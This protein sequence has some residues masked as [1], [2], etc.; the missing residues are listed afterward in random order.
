[1]PSVVCCFG[2]WY[3]WTNFSSRCHEYWPLFPCPQKEGFSCCSNVW[4]HFFNRSLT[5]YSKWTAECYQW[6]FSWPSSDLFP[7]CFRYG[8][9]WAAYSLE[10]NP[11]DFFLQSF[12]KDS[13]YRNKPHKLRTD[14]INLSSCEQHQWTHFGWSDWKFGDSY[15]QFWMPV[16]HIQ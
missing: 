6:A 8:W 12:L 9:S 14:E 16:V 4:K 13:V 7:T 1:M 2:S 10:L 15:I 11:C 5:A 3:C